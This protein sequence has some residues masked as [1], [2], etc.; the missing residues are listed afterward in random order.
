MRVLV[1]DQD[2][3]KNAPGLRRT[4]DEAIARAYGMVFATLNWDLRIRLLKKVLMVMR[5]LLLQPNIISSSI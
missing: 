1:W 4:F 3:N 2:G 5:M